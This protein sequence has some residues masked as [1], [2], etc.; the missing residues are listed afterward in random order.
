MQDSPHG[1]SFRDLDVRLQAETV[2]F[3]FQNLDTAVTVDREVR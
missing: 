2:Q 3:L 1:G